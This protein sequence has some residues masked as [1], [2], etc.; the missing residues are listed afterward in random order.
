MKRGAKP[1]FCV[2]SVENLVFHS[3][4]KCTFLILINLSK[5]GWTFIYSQTITEV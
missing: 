2:F 1:K 4:K 5:V 3:G